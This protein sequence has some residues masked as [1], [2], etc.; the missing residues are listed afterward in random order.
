MITSLVIF[1]IAGIMA[2]VM[3]AQLADPTSSLLSL[4]DLQR[5]V[6]HARQPDAVPVRRTVRLRRP[7]Q[8]HRAAAGRGARHGLPPAQ[9]PLLLALPR[10]LDHHAARASWSPAARPRS[11]GWPTRRSPTRSTPPAPGADLW[12]MALALTG[13]SAI[14][15]GVNLCATI[16]YLRAPGMTM[17]RMPIFTWNM[18]VTGILILIAFPVLVRRGGDALLRP[19]LRHAHLLGAGRR[20]TGPVA[21]PLLVLRPPGGVHPRLALLRDRHRDLPGLLAQAA[22]RLQGHGLRHHVHR[23]P[24]DRRVGAPHVH[25]RRRAAALLLAA[26]PT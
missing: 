13:F 15:T 2:L 24:V 25:H 16:F 5:A 20:G 3:R 10:R 21:E 22:L 18:L 23:R 4:P 12:I 6:H 7:G 26:R 14:F 8:L 9:R 19:P 1:F 17:F 11:A